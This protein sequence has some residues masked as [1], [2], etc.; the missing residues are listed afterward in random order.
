MAAACSILNSEVMQDCTPHRDP[1]ELRH[2]PCAHTPGSTSFPGVRV[3]FFGVRA[4]AGSILWSV[5]AFASRHGRIRRTSAGPAP[6][7]STRSGA[8]DPL[9]RRPPLVVVPRLYDPMHARHTSD[10]RRLS[11]RHG[12]GRHARSSILKGLGRRSMP[13]SPR[14]PFVGDLRRVPEPGEPF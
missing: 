13:P 11:I 14:N 12:P 6:M 9:H 10:R 8:I 2:S 7:S 3:W 5:A 4:A 1:P